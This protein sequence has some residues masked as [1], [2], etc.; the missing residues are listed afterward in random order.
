MVTMTERP[1]AP[2]RKPRNVA[3]RIEAASWGSFFVWVGFALLLQLPIG[4]GLIGVGAITLIAQAT[5]KS[6][7][8]PLEGFWILVGLAFVIGGLWNLYS[9]QIPFA[10]VLLVAVGALLLAVSFL[11]KGGED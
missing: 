11:G 4:V 1:P 8:L 9:I 7:E 5:R 6:F 2:T 3:K 10:A